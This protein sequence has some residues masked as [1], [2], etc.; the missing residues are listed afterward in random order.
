MSDWTFERIAGPYGGT[1]EGPAW[2]GQALLFTHIP[3]NRII[4][5]VACWSG[6]CPGLNLCSGV[7]QRQRMLHAA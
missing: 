5:L 3:A 7:Q 2:D 4:W 6:A 1:T